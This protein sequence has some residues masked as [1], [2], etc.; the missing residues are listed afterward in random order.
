MKFKTLYTFESRFEES[1]RIKDKYPDR[2]PIIC[3]K[4][5]NKKNDELPTIDKIKYLVP[6]NLTIS[7]FLF[8]IRRK[9]QLPAEKAIFLFVGNTIPSSSVFISN[10]YSQHKDLD[11]FLYI[12]YSGENVFGF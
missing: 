1:K 12:T 3:E 9:M 10:I 11:G 7:Q 4:I 6:T 2:I 8:V 5:D